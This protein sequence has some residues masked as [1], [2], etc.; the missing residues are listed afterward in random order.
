VNCAGDIINAALGIEPRA[1]VGVPLVALILW[2]LASRQV[3]SFFQ[4]SNAKAA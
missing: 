4:A 2:Y 3:K 1:V